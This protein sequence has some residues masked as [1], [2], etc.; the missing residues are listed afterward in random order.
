MAFSWR[1]VF[2]RETE[3]MGSNQEE[4]AGRGDAGRGET[5]EEI[6]EENEDLTVSLY[7]YSCNIG[8]A[9]NYGFEMYPSEVQ[10]E[11]DYKICVDGNC[12]Y[13]CF[14]LTGLKSRIFCTSS[15]ELGNSA[16]VQLYHNNQEIFSDTKQIPECGVYEE[17][18]GIVEGLVSSSYYLDDI[19]TIKFQFDKNGKYVIDVRL[20]NLNENYK[21]NSILYPDLSEGVIELQGPKIVMAQFDNFEEA[22]FLYESIRRALVDLKNGEE[23]P[24]S[25]STFLKVLSHDNCEYTNSYT[26]CHIFIN[27]NSVDIIRLVEGI[28]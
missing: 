19:Q 23:I 2:T 7:S 18:T 17:E 13:S 14:K 24:L 25:S 11:D 26:S 27:E 20:D 28:K 22:K 15:E 5:E 1:D 12:E 9:V 16:Q 8:G 3:R 4:D 10:D 6:E 21:S